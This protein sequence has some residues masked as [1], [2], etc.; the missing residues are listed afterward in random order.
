MDQRRRDLPIVAFALG[1]CVAYYILA[2]N[3]CPGDFQGDSWEYLGKAAQIRV[4]GRT[5][6]SYLRGYVYP[7]F[8]ATTWG[9]DGTFTYLLQQALLLCALYFAVRVLAFT[10]RY[11]LLPIVAAMIPAVAF[12]QKQL[13]P[14]GILVSLVLL[15]FALVAAKHWV[16]AVV[17]ALLLALT[18]LI[19]LAVVPCAIVAYLISRKPLK[20]FTIRIAVT[21]AVMAPVALFLFSMTF[22]DLAYM[23]VF[24]RPYSRGYGLERVL[25]GETLLIE[26]GGKMNSVPR[27]ELFWEPITAPYPIAS[28]G[29]LS[30]AKA[31]ALGC[32]EGELRSLKRRLILAQFWLDPFQ[33]IRLGARAFLLS[34]GGQYDL[35]HVSYILS[36]RRRL[37]RTQYNEGAYFTDNERK[38]LAIHRSRGMNIDQAEPL[39]FP[40]NAAAAA[41]GEA[42]IRFVAIA[43]LVICLTLSWRRQSLGILKDETA[44]AIGLFLLIYSASIAVSVPVVYDRYVYVNLLLLCIL[45]ARLAALTFMPDRHHDAVSPS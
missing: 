16:G 13:Y 14:D 25:P 43:T 38:L 32:N 24:V 19:Y 27:S 23:V 11:A 12:L 39:I 44:V 26:C 30:P 45:A 29:P 3:S 31:A 36:D 8:L 1:L 21:A 10:S 42:V 28:D 4:E 17:A 2:N 22:V 15:F 41:G 9:H 40:L 6:Y 35:A 37:W 18:K 20:L 7:W 5:P 34:L 33:H